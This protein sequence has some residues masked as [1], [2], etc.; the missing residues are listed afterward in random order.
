MS[1]GAWVFLVPEETTLATSGMQETFTSSLSGQDCI[2][3]FGCLFHKSCGGIPHP[4][5]PIQNETPM[6]HDTLIQFQIFKMFWGKY[7]QTQSIGA[8]FPQQGSESKPLSHSC[9]IWIATRVWLFCDTP[10]IK[11]TDKVC[12][13]AVYN[14]NSVWNCALCFQRTGLKWGLK[15]CCRKTRLVALK[16]SQISSELLECVS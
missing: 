8:H 15:T 1:T 6:R 7:L 11:S 10:L 3:L 12:I 13:R 4:D 14:G 16:R 5:D 2:C 9:A